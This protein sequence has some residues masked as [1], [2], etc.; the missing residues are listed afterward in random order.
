M[1]NLLIGAAS[2]ICHRKEA[3]HHRRRRNK[4]DLIFYYCHGNQWKPHVSKALYGPFLRLNPAFALLL[5]LRERS[6][7]TTGSVEP[8]TSCANRRAETRHKPEYHISA[9]A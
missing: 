8:G 2:A 1:V 9:R 6:N 5:R 7:K 4:G 3:T